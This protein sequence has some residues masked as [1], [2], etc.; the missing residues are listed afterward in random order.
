MC[1]LRRAELLQNLRGQSRDTIGLQDKTKTGFCKEKRNSLTTAPFPPQG[2][3]K[4]LV[5]LALGPL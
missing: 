5:V 3:A 1:G 2:P 4:T